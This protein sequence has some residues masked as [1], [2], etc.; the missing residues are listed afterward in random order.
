MNKKSPGIILLL[1]ISFSFARA[2]D[3]EDDAQLWLNLYVEKKLGDH[4]DV[5]LSHSSR[6]GE[7]VSNYRLGYGEIGLSYA[8]NQ[9]IKVT[10]GYS[11]RKRRNLNGT[12]SDRHR[13]YANVLLK[14][15]SDRFTL[16]Y[17]YRFQAE[18]RDVY[19]SEYGMVPLFYDRHKVTVKYELF[20]RWDIYVTEELFYP[21]QQERKKGLD[22]SRSSFGLIFDLSRRTTLQGSFIYRH[23]LNAFNRTNRDFV[24]ALAYAYEF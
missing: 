10:A 17:R 21:Y 14:K 12:F 6:F 18:L 24:Y 1:L 13:V 23:E 20:K 15:K 19:V 9:N 4:F 11:L 5:H 16:S 8:R 7:N 3:Y 22:E 2:Q